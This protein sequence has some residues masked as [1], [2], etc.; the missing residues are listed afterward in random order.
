MTT[1]NH[2][3]YTYPDNKIDISSGSGRDGAVKYADFALGKMIESAK[4][5]HGL[6]IPFL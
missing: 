1:S 4:K 5:N 6:K 2:R 3:P